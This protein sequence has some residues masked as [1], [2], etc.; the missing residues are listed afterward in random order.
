[1]IQ[2]IIYRDSGQ[3]VQGQLIAI[4]CNRFKGH[5]SGHDSRG[6]KLHYIYRGKGQQVQNYFSGIAFFSIS[7]MPLF[8]RN[9]RFEAFL[10][11]CRQGYSQP[12]FMR[13]WGKFDFGVNVYGH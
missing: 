11:F 4:D 6:N 13:L 9:L 3:Q 10:C 5:D 8:V 12:L 7:N 1:M 2:G